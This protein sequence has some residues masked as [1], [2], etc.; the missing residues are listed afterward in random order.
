M[1]KGSGKRKCLVPQWLYE[2]RH[3]LAYG[4]I[5]PKGYI[6]ILKEH[7]DENSETD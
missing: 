6:K 3:D 4:L 1:G 5:T 2:A 7:E